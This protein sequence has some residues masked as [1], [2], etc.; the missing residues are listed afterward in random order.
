MTKAQ[1]P[2]P[3]KGIKT[4]ECSEILSRFEFKT[5]DIKTRGILG[6]PMRKD[7]F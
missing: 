7:F 4:T 2:H 3:R 6:K 1:V 5:G